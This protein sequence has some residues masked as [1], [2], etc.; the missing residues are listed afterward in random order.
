MVNSFEQFSNEEAIQA[1]ESEIIGKY[2]E[3]MMK[4]KIIVETKNLFDE[5]ITEYEI[6]NRLNR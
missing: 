2:N 4:Y 3:R 1:L 5:M 6:R